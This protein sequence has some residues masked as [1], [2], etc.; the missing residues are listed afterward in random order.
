MAV[1]SFRKSIGRPSLAEIAP[2]AVLR[3]QTAKICFRPLLSA[4]RAVNPIAG[5]DLTTAVELNSRIVVGGIV[6]KSES[7]AGAFCS[8]RKQKSLA[9][10]TS[11]GSHHGGPP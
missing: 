11:T 7:R 8:S 10:I 6:I 9:A 3:G 2:A 5:F 1:P 4:F